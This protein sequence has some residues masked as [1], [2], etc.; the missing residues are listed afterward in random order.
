[1]CIRDRARPEY[2]AF[3]PAAPVDGQC[4]TCHVSAM[5]GGDRNAFGLDAEATIDGDGPDWSK[6]YCMDSDGDGKTNG[7]EL[8]DPCGA[9]SPGTTP[10]RTEPVSAPGDADDTVDIDD[11]GACA[12]AAAPTCSSPAGAVGCASVPVDAGALAL[13]LLGA[14]FGLKRRTRLA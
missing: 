11:E 14:L 9:W 1:M 10:E 12:G 2:P 7:Q 3:I 6:L 8:G 13:A 5:G 4:G